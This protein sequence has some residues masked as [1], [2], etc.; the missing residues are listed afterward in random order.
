MK[1]IQY[2]NYDAVDSSYRDFTSNGYEAMIPALE[3]LFLQHIPKGGQVLDLGCG[4]GKLAQLLQMKGYQLTGIDNSEVM[5][6]DAHKNAPGAE[7]ILEDARFFKLPPTFHA[8]YTTGIPL[9]HIASIEELTSVFQNVYAA[10]LENGLFTFD[11]R[12]EEQLQSYYEEHQLPFN[13]PVDP[14]NEV[15]NDYVCAI[16]RLYEPEDK[17]HKINI[18]QFHLIKG[19]WQRSDIIWLLRCYSTAEVQSAM[20][21]AGFQEVKIYDLKRDLGL[22]KTDI[23]CFVGRKL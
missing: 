12:V 3:K 1:S 5:L 11:L 19:E 7:F 17:V 20:E 9:N 23:V 4:S 21:A 6:S 14:F 2:N 16:N 18:T 15:K 22:D 8:A 10:L 13:T